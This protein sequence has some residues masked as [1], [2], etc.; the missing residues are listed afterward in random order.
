MM[1]TKRY[2]TIC[3]KCHTRLEVGQ[4]DLEVG[5]GEEELK[6]ALAGSDWISRIVECSRC[7]SGKQYTLDEMI[8]LD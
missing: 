8:L 2:G 1:Q 7:K 5:A 3:T 4:V 6:R